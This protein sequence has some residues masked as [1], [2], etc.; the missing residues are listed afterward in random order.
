MIPNLITIPFSVPTLKHQHL[1]D[2]TLQTQADATAAHAPLMQANV[3][4]HVHAHSTLV[5]NT[6]HICAVENPIQAKMH[7]NHSNKQCHTQHSLQDTPLQCLT[8]K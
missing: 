3:T 1:G 6:G 8:L 5:R 7:Y 4:N 2:N